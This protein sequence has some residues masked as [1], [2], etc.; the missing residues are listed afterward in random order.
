MCIIKGFRPKFI[1][2]VLYINDMN[3]IGTPG[4][5]ENI[6]YCLKEKFEMEIFDKTKFCLDFQTEHTKNGFLCINPVIKTSP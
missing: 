2:S 6:T 3:I 4:E 1:I 5:L